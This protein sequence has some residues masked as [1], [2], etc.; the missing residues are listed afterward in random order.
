MGSAIKKTEKLTL[1]PFDIKKG[2]VKL[3]SSKPFNVIDNGMKDYLD[4]FRG[5]K[6]GAVG[7]NPDD[8]EESFN[9]MGGGGGGFERNQSSALGVGQV[10]QSSL[11]VHV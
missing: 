3:A 1:K 5:Q 8:I 2:G 11:P 10:S 4:P 6:G 7:G 9:G